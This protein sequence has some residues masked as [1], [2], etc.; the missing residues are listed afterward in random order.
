MKGLKVLIASLILVLIFLGAAFAQEVAEVAEDEKVSAQDL[1]IS[2]PKWLPDHPLYFLKNWVR[3]IQL[4]F[5][6]DRA[7]K[8]ELRLKFANEKIVEA[9]KLAELKGNPRA[10]EKVLAS[11]E[12]DIAK[13]SELS[14]EDLKKFS[15]KLV[16]QQILHQKILQKLETQVPPEVLEKIK[17]QRE[18][19]LERFAKVMQKVEAKEKI[20][21]RLENE[22]EKIK[23]S[24]F[25]EFKDLEILTEIG[26]KMPEEVKKKIEER[27]AKIE[28]KFREKLEGMPDE[29]KEKFKTYLDQISGNKLKHLEIISNLEAEEISDKLSDVLEE[30]K[31][32]KID[33]VEKETISADQAQSQIKKAEDEIAK[34]EGVIGTISEEEYGGKAARKLL[35]LAKK[36]FKEAKLAFDEGKYGRAFGLAITAYHEA[37]NSERIAQKIEEIKKSPEKMKEKME[38]LYPGIELPEDLTKCQ[39]PLMRKC[40]EGEVLRVE[41]TAEGCPRFRCEKIP[42]PEEKIVCPMLWDPVCGKDG[43]TYSNECFAKAAGVEIDHKGM[44][45]MPEKIQEKI[46]ERLRP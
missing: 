19:H 26:E 12:N 22:L 7:K 27:K 21:E 9:K 45:R 32:G 5:T 4:V 20:A 43:K 34:A 40:A 44:C 29:E 8:A 25:K 30:A 46:E 18:K 11:F 6:F 42:K 1:G 17:T 36:H 14:G 3:G 39:I 41:K 35:D 24:K 2:E 28:E 37:L 31:E 16:H 10:I 23:G 13:I 33:E 15:E 38:S